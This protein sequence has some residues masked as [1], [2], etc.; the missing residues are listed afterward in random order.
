MDLLREKMRLLPMSG[1]QDG[2]GGGGG[3]STGTQTSIQELPEWAR[4][5]AQNI[6]AKGEALTTSTTP[7][8]YG[9]DRYAGLSDLQK[10]A[11]ESVS[12][13]E[14]YNKSLQGFMDPYAQNV[15]DIQK[16]EA[17][18][19]SQMA[20]LQE[21][22]Q[23]VKA[24]A[25]GGSRAGLVEAERARNTGQL[26]SDIQQRGSEAAYQ[27]AQQA[28]QRDIANKMQIGTMQ[29]A[30]IQRPMDIAY[31]DFLN[32][33]NYPYKQLGFMSDLLRGTPTGSSSVTNMY[34]PISG[35]QTLAGLGM[36]A[37]GMSKLFAK[38]G[39]L[40]ESSYAE[41]GSVDS[42]DNVAEIVSGLSDAQLE[43]AA[44]AAQSRGD[45]E[46]LQIIQA[47]KAM[48]VSE[49]G[50]LAGAFNNLPYPTRARMASGGIVAFA[51]DE[52]DNDPQ[53]GQL[54]SQGNPGAYQNAL[55]QALGYN[56]GLSE[57]KENTLSPEE[58]DAAIQR[59][60]ALEQK[61]AG[62]SPYGDINK[63]IAESEAGIKDY[64]DKAKGFAALKAMGAIMQPGGFI[65]G[66]GAAGGAFGDAMEKSE[67]ATRAE[68][69][70][71]ASMKFNLKDAE[72][73]ER[74]GMTRSAVSAASEAIKD[75]RD[76]ERS[77]LKVLETQANVAAK[78]AQAAKPVGSGSGRAPQPKESVAQIAS[79]AA[80]I[81][82]DNPGMDDVDVQDQ[83]TRQYF[84]M[85]K[86]G[87]SG[88]AA[89]T[90]TDALKDYEKYT[91][92]K[93][94]QVKQIIKEQFG[95]NEAAFKDDFMARIMQ[96]LPTD[97][98]SAK[99]GVGARP[100]TTARGSTPPPPPGFVSQ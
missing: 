28:L 86:S 68:K 27:N 10:K 70:S 53:T 20:G 33:Q 91:T 26:L 69:R 31:Q 44:K 80:K 41:G 11:I 45:F 58:V 47:E 48:R 65:R 61:L 30:D 49:R 1:P 93:P 76:A 84:S 72:R 13:P 3:A 75:K 77:R 2:G 5:Y 96:G 73:K 74:M 21:A 55:M 42:P 38:D 97:V 56:K 8:T 51:G 59:R 71:L 60:Y 23:A 50:G 98:Y 16:R 89:K 79:L 32:Q 95:G 52:E 88:A 39:G 22:G 62:E 90:Y 4:P 18:R 57:F 24:G 17:G 43:Q 67:Q 35:A 82:K 12:T 94:S 85:T 46:Q 40:M 63:H 36:G 64:T 92:L 6:L 15:I 9:G 83:A 14:A 37:Y 54:V 34:Q 19:Q 78:I 25:F 66:L 81:R 100:K 29:Q 99:Q 87:T 7:A